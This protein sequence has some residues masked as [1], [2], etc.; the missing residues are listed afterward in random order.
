MML[1]YADVLSIEETL[2]QLARVPARE[3]AS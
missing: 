2:E 3:A 1:K